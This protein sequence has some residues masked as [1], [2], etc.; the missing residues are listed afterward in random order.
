MRLTEQGEVLAERYDNRHIAHRHLEQL[1]WATLLASATPD[2]PVE[3]RWRQVISEASQT[4]QRTYRDLIEQPAFIDYFRRATPIDQIETL[5]IGSR[6][7]RR[8]GIASLDDLRAIPYTF[9][10]TQSRQVL[11]GFYGMGTALQPLVDSDLQLLRTMYQRWPFFRA[12]IDNAELGLIRFDGAIAERYAQLA[13]DNAADVHQRIVEEFALAEAAVLAIKQVDVLAE[14]QPWLRAAF[15]RRNP[16]VDLLNLVQCDL[17]KRCRTLD[18]EPTS[19]LSLAARQ[20]IQAI[21]SGLRTT[22]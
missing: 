1:T 19:E 16:D 17:L 8:R 10:W 21:A 20:T 15:Q 9:A 18:L 2:Q 3:P 13:G 4:A 7:S 22:G 14:A 11:T 6:P 5:P 12:V